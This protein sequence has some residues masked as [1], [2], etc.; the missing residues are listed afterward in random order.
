MNKVIFLGTLLCILCHAFPMSAQD[1]SK[2]DNTL[3]IIE[4]HE[5][6]YEKADKALNKVYREAMKS[7]SP[8]AQQ[9][10]KE[11]QKTWLNYRDTG[12][13]FAIEL[14]K[15]LRSYGNIVVADY[16]AT[17]VEKRVLELRYLMQ[18]PEEPPIKW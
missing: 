8:F 11:S 15:D 5:K 7:L 6:R 2:A 14:N 12:L 13:A 9:K 18:G 17:V 4:C 3:S 1:C 10:L 16:K